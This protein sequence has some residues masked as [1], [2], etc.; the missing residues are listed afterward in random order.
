MAVADIERRRVGAALFC[1]IAVALLAFVFRDGW[2]HGYVLGQADFLFEMPPWE[3]ARPPGWRT[4]NTLL[5]DIP[6]VFYP[7]LLHARTAVLNGEF[8]LWSSAMGGGLPFFASY[9]EQQVAPG[10]VA[11]VFAATALLHPR[12]R[13]HAVFFLTTGLV[14]ALVMYG[15]F[16]T[17]IAVFLVPPLRVALLS[18]FGLITIIGLI[19]AAAIGI[20]ALF[21]NG[22]EGARSR[23]VRCAVAATVAAVTIVLV[24]LGFMVTEHQFLVDMRQWTQT[25]RSVTRAGTLLGLAIALVWLAGLLRR[26]V[27]LVLTVALL[28][29]ELVSFADGFHPSIPRDLVFPNV[30]ALE[31]IQRDRSVF[32]VAGWQNAMLPNA[33]RVYGLQDVRSYDGIGHRDYSAVLELGFHFNG[34]TY[35]LVNTSSRSLVD[36]LNIKYVVAAGDVD[37]PPNDFELVHQD[38]ARVYRNRHVQPRAFLVDNSVVLAGREA[39][40]A[41]RDGSVDLSRAAIVDQPIDAPLQP[42]QSGE[43]VGTAT[44][45]HYGDHLVSIETEAEAARL[46]VLTDVYYPG[47]IASVDG[48]EVPVRR[49]NYAFRAVSVPPGRHIVT[50]R[51]RPA[52]VRYGAYLS[53]A[54][55]LVLGALMLPRRTA[56]R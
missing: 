24:V 10:I 36:L 6:L 21:A 17:K 42:A 27:A 25:V 29:W 33:A 48:V 45:Q 23:R 41:I 22:E 11:C 54:G 46:L 35:Q 18:R 9:C 13:G 51:Y 28:S 15:T 3:G 56:K 34:N 16:V 43:S 2:L 12:R 49:A 40:R 1:G 47:W 32:R 19:V 50:F 52:S 7:F 39:L 44:I 38:R 4:R 26:P 53:L 14:A 30:A 37:L 20:D 5:G 55:L 8:P 31:L